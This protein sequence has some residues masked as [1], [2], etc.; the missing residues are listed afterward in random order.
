MNIEEANAI[1]MFDL[2]EKLGCKSYRDYPDS[3]LYKSP[4]RI[5]KTASFRV[6][7]VKNVWYD[8]GIGKGGSTFRFVLEYLKSQNV[9]HTAGDGLRFLNRIWGDQPIT[10]LIPQ[11]QLAEAD[12]YKLKEKLI[13]SIKHPALINYLKDR[14]IPLEIAKLYFKEAE[15]L[16]T[17]SGKTFKAIALKNESS[18]YELKNKIFKGTI[19]Q[20]DISFIRGTNEEQKRVQVFE[21]M[22]DFVSVLVLLDI[23]RLKDDAIILNS[24]SCLTKAFPIIEI[25]SYEEVY[26]YF[27]NDKA[28]VNHREILKEF[29]QSQKGLK[30]VSLHT[31]YA[32]Y[33]D[34]NEWLVAERNLKTLKVI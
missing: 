20:K 21:G 7:K 19:N 23:K 8:H 2:L 17:N 30:H 5:E 6:N 27:D 3:A 15:V 10:P 16:N 9:D 28:G 4:L 32:N 34:V 25:S 33:K 12:R 22:M 13:Y 18:G 31:K 29:I 14:C 24:L 1:P 26:S 11:S